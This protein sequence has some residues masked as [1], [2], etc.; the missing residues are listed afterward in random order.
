LVVDSGKTGL[1]A[2]SRWGNGK[3]GRT[4]E[5]WLSQSRTGEM[6]YEKGRIV[7]GRFVKRVIFSKIRRDVGGYASQGGA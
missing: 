4:T 2:D 7:L 3:Q 6:Q 5:K 1:I